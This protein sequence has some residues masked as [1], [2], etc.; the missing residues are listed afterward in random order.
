MQVGSCSGSLQVQWE[1]VICTY[2][3][4]HHSNLMPTDLQSQHLHRLTVRARSPTMANQEGPKDELAVDKGQLL[5]QTT[6]ITVFFLLLKPPSCGAR[7]TTT[8]SSALSV[9]CCG[10]KHQVRQEPRATQERKAAW[11][12]VIKRQINLSPQTH[13]KTHLY[14]HRQSSHKYIHTESARIACLIFPLKVKV[15]ECILFM[16][17]FKILSK[18]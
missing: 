12:C 8:F 1:Q 6:P 9:N 15:T 2:R 16:P 5:A 17:G 10:K 18:K 3:Q 13:G 4:E 11:E 14:R 7:G